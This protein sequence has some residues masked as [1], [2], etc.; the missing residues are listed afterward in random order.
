MRALAQ[1]PCGAIFLPVNHFQAA[2]QARRV[3]P[4]LRVPVLMRVR[5]VSCRAARIPHV[6]PWEVLPTLL[7]T[8][9][10]RRGVLVGGG[11]STRVARGDLCLPA[12]PAITGC[13][14]WR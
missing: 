6:Q 11:H 1:P 12:A 13:A 10:F 7:D 9:G 3:S 8:I 5:A 4:I 14:G 2:T